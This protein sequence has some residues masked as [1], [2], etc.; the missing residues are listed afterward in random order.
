MLRVETLRSKP[1]TYSTS[2]LK[3]LTPAMRRAKCRFVTSFIIK[4][5]IK[6]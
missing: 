5:I 4:L 1:V 2:I 6:L 3:S